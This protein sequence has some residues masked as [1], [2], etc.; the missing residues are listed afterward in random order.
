MKY[1]AVVKGYHP[2][3]YT[4]W[5]T[6]LKEVRGYSG[7]VYKSFSTQKNAEQ[8]LLQHQTQTTDS[9]LP[10]I[11]I[12]TDG[13]YLAPNAGF[14]V[15][16]IKPNGKKY[17]AYG[18]VSLKKVDSAIAELYAIYVALSLVE[19]DVVIYSDS[20]YAVDAFS[21][22]ITEWKK[23]SWKG[24]KNLELIQAIDKLTQNRKVKWKKVKAHV[25]IPENELVDRLANEGRQSN[26]DLIVK[27]EDG[28]K[29]R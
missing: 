25:G 7:A 17:Y 16:I 10:K 1:Y 19:E 24:V 20:Q 14:G 22:Y 8:F 2:G 6:T 4:D 15:L 21:N 29:F 3:I 5:P 26:K 27:R 12:Y 11:V 23:N 28:K 9:P 18:Q 13:S